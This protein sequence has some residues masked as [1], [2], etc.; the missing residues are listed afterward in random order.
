MKGWSLEGVGLRSV[1]WSQIAEISLNS[2]QTHSWVYSKNLK[3]LLPNSLGEGRFLEQVWWHQTL[4]V[5]SVP[6]K[7]GHCISCVDVIE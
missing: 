6:A 1:L 4:V 5:S 2:P 7:D 3:Y